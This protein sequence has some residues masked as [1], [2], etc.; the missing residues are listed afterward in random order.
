M[1]KLLSLADVVVAGDG[2]K[3]IF[4]ALDHDYKAGL[5]DGD[6]PK[7]PLFLTNQELDDLPLPARHLIDLESYHYSIEGARATSIISQLGCPF[8]YAILQLLARAL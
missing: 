1:A 5:I 3:A 7:S 6:D 4:A 2:E 8:F